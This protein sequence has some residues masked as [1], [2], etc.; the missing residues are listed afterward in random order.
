M[1]RFL[2]ILVLA[3]M[4]S[5]V[6]KADNFNDALEAYKKG[7]YASAL[8]LW[9]PLAEKGNAAAQYNLGQMYRR[10]QGVKQD[11]E[12]AA[13]WYQKAAEKGNAA[14]QFNL[15]VK[16]R[17]GEGVI[18]DFKESVKWYRKAAEQGDADAQN[19]LGVKYA[20]GRGVIQD[21]IR[22]HMWMNIAASNG[23]KDGSSNRDIVAKKMTAAQIAEAQKMAREC[24][25]K[26]YKNC[27]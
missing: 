14:A 20:E 15:G 19:S 21:Y 2:L 9:Q 24:E 17:K 26:N 1:K 4:C 8:K 5:S 22:A 7:D 3:V 12:K 11:Y 13:S 23:E 27:D 16:Y 18:Q 10:G 6:A 25:K